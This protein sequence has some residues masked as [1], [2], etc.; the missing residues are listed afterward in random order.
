MVY[1]LLRT[2]L[3]KPLR[4]TSF[5]L[6]IVATAI[7]ALGGAPVA[8]QA[9]TTHAIHAISR[10]SAALPQLAPPAADCHLGAWGNKSG[11][12]E[13][14]I[15]W[16]CSC[17]SRTATDPTLTC[18]WIAV[19]YPEA[20]TPWTNLHS[21]LVLEVQHSELFDSATV[22]IWPYNGSNTQYWGVVP[23]GSGWNQIINYNSGL[24]L[25]VGNSGSTAQGTDVIQWQCN[26][27]TDQQ[28]IFVFRGIYHS[29]LPVFSIHD[30]RSGLCLD[31]PHSSTTA[32]TAL[33][34][35]ACNGS[36]A[37]NWW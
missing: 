30:R 23:H 11:P 18:E 5:R 32:G 13:D 16:Q 8:A 21:G 7:A 37:Q 17:H 2:K 9:S 36:D 15:T 33:W 31:V 24:C 20:N 26:G 27:A 14:G 4:T 25:A 10:T 19:D 1:Q 3:A 6:L 34:Q 35:W 28:W 12:D 22:D 29:G